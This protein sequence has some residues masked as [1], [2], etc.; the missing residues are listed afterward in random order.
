MRCLGV[1][2]AVIVLGAS[3]AS[4]ALSASNGAV[5]GSVRTVATIKGEVVAFAQDRRYLAWLLVGPLNE[6]GSGNVGVVGVRDLRT[7]RVERLP[8]QPGS[9][10]PWFSLDLEGLA[11][12]GGR[13]FWGQTY[14]S[15][16]TLDMQL[17]TA[18][19]GDRR[20]RG[21]C[22]EEVDRS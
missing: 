9:A 1:S 2:A 8:A 18:S 19:V 3:S 22:C 20:L 10:G 14:V 5:D 15:N 4:A 11:L 16:N 7:G 6:L 13:A 17:A 21:V 12:S